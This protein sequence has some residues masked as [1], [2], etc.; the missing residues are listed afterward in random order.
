VQDL[1]EQLV[2][3]NRSIVA[4]RDAIH[5]LKAEWSY[6]NQ[7]TRLAELSHRHL[8][9][10]PIGT[11]QLGS[12]DALPMKAGAPLVASIAAPTPVAA[13]PRTAMAGSS[14]ASPKFKSN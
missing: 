13:G 1:E 9:L 3:I 10:Q 12:L 8:Q 7:P 4:D 2:K 6:L 5:V 14:M 11:A